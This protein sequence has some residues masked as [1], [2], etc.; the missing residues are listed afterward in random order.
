MPLMVEGAGVP[1]AVTESGEG[2]PVLVVHDI[3]RPPRTDGLAGR[4]IAYE[5][6]GYGASGAPEPYEATTV[7][8]QAED[9]AAVLRQV[10][11][12]PA[13]L[14]G[15]G[16]GALI[17]LDVA[18]RH[19]ELVAALRLVDPPLFA[20]VPE[21]AEALSTERARLAE[22]MRS[23]GPQ[24]A[25]DAHLGEALPWARAAHRAVFADLAGL[26]SWP[27]TRGDLRSLD[28]P[29]AVETSPGA[30]PHVAAAVAA[31]AALLPA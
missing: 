8:E 7:Q 20:F 1:L 22:A 12:E 2:A 29:V 11:G 16:F 9:A 17:A 21:A 23:G 10:A 24:A 30:P 19:R 26:A 3:G 25:V 13:L 31:L 6:R 27:V 28:L 18:L 15:D 5:R 4:V 14:A